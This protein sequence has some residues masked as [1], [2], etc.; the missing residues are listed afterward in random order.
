MSGG[1]YDD[2]KEWRRVWDDLQKPNVVQCTC[3]SRIA[4]GK[5]DHPSFH[6]SWCAVKK[7]YEMDQ[8]LKGAL[9]VP[10]SY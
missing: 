8:K 2:T 4:L 10:K 3:G 5:D 7:D 6:S 1:Y 9:N